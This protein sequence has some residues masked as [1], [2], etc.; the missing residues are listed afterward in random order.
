MAKTPISTEML[1]EHLA[2]QLAFL[3][4]SARA[5][6]QGFEAEA[7]RLAIALRILL[8]D[9]GNSKSLLG[10]V[11]MKDGTFI[12]TLLPFNSDSLTAYSG[13]VSIALGPP[14]TRF[15][16]LLDDVPIRTE[17][18]FADWWSEPV[19]VDQQ[20][21]PMTREQL[22]R[23]MADQDG[24]AHVDPNLDAQY[25]ALIKE[26]SLNWM[27]SNGAGFTPMQDPARAAIRQIA[28]EVLKS[29]RPDYSCKVNHE[30]SAIVGGMSIVVGSAP[31]EAPRTTIRSPQTHQE[32]GKV[33]RNAPC[34]CRS[35]KKY[36]HCHGHHSFRP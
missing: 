6:D 20:R 36:K 30:A 17:K 15:V 24:G 28:H 29:L 7:K 25:H 31:P 34:P 8:S 1:Q 23:T 33:R 35:G 27:S 3:E 19:F 10:Q 18:S 9:R 32:F 5:F 11:E 14:K 21:R 26:N 22:V 12:S 16:A 4:A 13:L 2:E